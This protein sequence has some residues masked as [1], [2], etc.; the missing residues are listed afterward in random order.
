MIEMSKENHSFHENAEKVFNKLPL[1]VRE[2]SNYKIFCSM[3]KKFFHDKDLTR[4][5]YLSII[6]MYQLHIT[7]YLLICVLLKLLSFQMFKMHNVNYA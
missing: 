3:T 6:V 5:M 4:I 1:R 7:F 2:K